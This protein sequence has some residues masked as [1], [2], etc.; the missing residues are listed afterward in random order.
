MDSIAGCV[1]AE[2]GESRKDRLAAAILNRIMYYYA[3]P[4]SRELIR[5]YREYSLVIGTE[6]FVLSPEGEKS[7]VV[8]GID[9]ACHLLVKYR[10]GEEAS[11]SYGEIRIGLQSDQE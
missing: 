6:V 10:N 5:K 8:L 11:L 3:Q 7:A 1:F 9:D 2:S 4:D